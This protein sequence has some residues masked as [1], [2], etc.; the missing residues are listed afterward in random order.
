MERVMSELANYLANLPGTEVH[1]VLYGRSREIF[2]DIDERIIVHKPGFRFNNRLRTLSTVKTL[3]FLRKT[4]KKINPD[5]ALSLGNLWNN[6]VLLSLL[7]V[8]VPLYISD[9]SQPGKQMGALQ[10][11]LR[12]RLYPRATGII[13]QT[14]KAEAFYRKTIG[15]PNIKVIGN[16]VRQIKAQNGKRERE[17]IVLSVGRLIDTKH[18]DDLIRMFLEVDKPGWRLVIVGDDALQQNNRVKLE[19]IIADHNAEE[20][21]ELAGQRSDVDDFYLKSKIFAF[22]SSSEGFPNVI[23]EAQS[24]GL[25]VVAFDCVAGPS[26]MVFDGRNGYLVPLFDYKMFK[27]RLSNLMESDEKRKLLGKQANEDIQRY[28][29]SEICQGFATFIAD[30]NLK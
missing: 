29:T 11:F 30:S 26:D 8:N 22:T 23:G 1:L 13:A 18:F 7:G 27:K 10:R 19:K 9:R 3:L 21:V 12:N 20:K 2:Y 6:F 5:T 28:D 4:V 15:H 16:P 17:N 25:P 14:E 24:A